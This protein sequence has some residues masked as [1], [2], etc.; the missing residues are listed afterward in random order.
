MW[1]EIERPEAMVISRPSARNLRTIPRLCL[2]RIRRRV[3]PGLRLPVGLLLIIAGAFG[4]LPILGFWMIPLGV[5]VAALDI[6]AILKAWR[7]NLNKEWLFRTKDS[8][9][10]LACNLV[11]AI[12]LTFDLRNN[13]RHTW[14]AGCSRGISIQNH[15]DNPIAGGPYLCK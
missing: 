13:P 12:A 2:R 8:R 9:I 14:Q 7:G 11:E 4:I 15:T 3:S 5:T 10:A 6:K 1:L